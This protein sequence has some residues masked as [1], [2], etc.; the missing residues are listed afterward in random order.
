MYMEAQPVCLQSQNV[1]AVEVWNANDKSYEQ[2]LWHP[3]L[4]SSCRPRVGATMEVMMGFIHDA[5]KEAVEIAFNHLLKGSND[6]P[7]FQRYFTFSFYTRY[8]T[9]C[10]TTE[11]FS[12]LLR[13]FIRDHVL[14]IVKV[15]VT[16]LYRSVN[17]WE[18]ERQK[19]VTFGSILR[20]YFEFYW[21]ALGR[22]CGRTLTEICSTM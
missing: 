15:S 9:P 5:Q 4:W 17:T 16:C 1:I 2:L 12:W 7:V 10:T 20:V 19:E 18:V 3:E 22:F 21:H 14:M 8:Y 11:R 13:S 6:T